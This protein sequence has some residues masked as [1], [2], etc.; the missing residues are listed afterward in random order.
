MQKSRIGAGIREFFTQKN[1]LDSLGPDTF[2]SGKPGWAE[3][4]LGSSALQHA[5]RLRGNGEPTNPAV[6]LYASAAR[7]LLQARALDDGKVALDSS[8]HA[9]FGAVNPTE[10]ELARVWLAPDGERALAGMAPQAVREAEGV[11]RRLAT[12]SRR[13]LWERTKRARRVVLRRWSRIALVP[14]LALACVVYFRPAKPLNHALHARVSI[15]NASPTY[16]PRLVVDGNRSNLGFHTLSGPNE[17]TIDLGSPKRV[18][19]VVVYN[20]ADCCTERAVPLSVEVQE[21]GKYRNVGTRKLVFE[22]WRVE[23]PATKTRFVRLIST[24]PE[25]FHLSEIEVY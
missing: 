5:N 23:F 17:L 20:R 12:A 18:S 2:W 21:N 16:P 3:F 4:V 22:I 15:P 25:A 7:L 14:L 6:L 1:A 19:R 9:A 8:E 24:N 11:L 13:T 10:R